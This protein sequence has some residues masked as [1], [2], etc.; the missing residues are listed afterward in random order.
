MSRIGDIAI[1]VIVGVGGIIGA[2]FAFDKYGT[3][4]GN[5]Y[6]DSTEDSETLEA[7]DSSDNLDSN[8]Q[9]E[10]SNFDEASQSTTHGVINFNTT[11]A[12]QN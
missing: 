9:E 8:E 11:L 1:G 10:V 7:T 4:D 6:E 2:A 12:I 3:S 5:S